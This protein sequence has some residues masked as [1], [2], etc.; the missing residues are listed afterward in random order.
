MSKLPDPVASRSLVPF[1]RPLPPIPQGTQ[2]A[3]RFQQQGPIA[4]VLD[5][6]PKRIVGEDARRRPTAIEFEPP[7]RPS[8]RSSTGTRPGRT[9]PETPPFGAST[10]FLA[11][12]IGQSVGSAATVRS[13]AERP[14]PALEAYKL[15]GSEPPPRNGETFSLAV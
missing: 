13:D 8:Y 6:R 3:D 7:E 5:G 15:A 4:E 14:D 12:L 2:P 11:Q 1:A 10:A 9:V